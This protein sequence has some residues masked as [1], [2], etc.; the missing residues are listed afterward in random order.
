MQYFIR[1]VALASLVA[2]STEAVAQQPRRP[3]PNYQVRGQLTNAPAGTRVLLIDDQTGQAM[4]IDS[5]RT[6]A[7]GRFQ[8]RGTVAGP[9]VYSLR[10]AG[11][12]RTTDVAL[13]P[14]S[15]LQLRADATQ[16]RGTSDITG[17]PEAAELARMHQE[18]FRL[19]A[20]I[21]TLVQRRAVTTDTAALRRIGQEW[22]ATFGAFRAAAQ[23]V[24]GQASY[25]APYVAA[26]FLSGTDAPAEV[27]FLDSA[28]TR[29]VRQWP[30]SPH[31][32]QLQR[33]QS[34]RQTTAVGRLAPEIL[35]PTPAGAPLALSSLRG[36]Y[37][38]IDFWAS[39]CGPCRQENPALVRTYQQF[40]GKGFEIYGVSVDSKKEAWLA[41]MQKDGLPW[42]QV[43][44][45]PSDTSVASTAYNIYKFPSSFLLDPQGRIIAKDL[46]GEDLTKKLAELMP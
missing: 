36:K 29:Y 16:L 10:V 37:V 34:M 30:A 14:G 12:R 7:K 28:T 2:A 9:G 18:Q 40:R 20:H 32:Q 25:V 6:D 23:R 4:P 17:T 24:A 31:T 8:L 15:Q 5:A 33:Y 21:D 41:A 43:R 44:D 22:D 13:A 3:A 27:A 38:L 26:T 11:Q 39:W 19:M 42:P 46:R 45:E 1:I 35:L